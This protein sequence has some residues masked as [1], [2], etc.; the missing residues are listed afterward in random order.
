MNPVP[1]SMLEKLFSEPFKVWL[2]QANLEGRSTAEG[3]IKTLNAGYDARSVSAF[4]D[5]LDNPTV[6]LAIGIIH[7]VILDKPTCAIYFLEGTGDKRDAVKTAEAYARLHGCGDLAISNWTYL[8]SGLK[9]PD[10]L[11][12]SFDPQEAISTYLL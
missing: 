10:S 2:S 4:V 8:D 11:E 12:S 6:L 5:D 1:Q 3:F 9:I 7:S